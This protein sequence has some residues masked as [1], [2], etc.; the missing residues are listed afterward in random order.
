VPQAAKRVWYKQVTLNDS[1]WTP[2]YPAFDC[3]HIAVRNLSESRV[4]GWLNKTV[5]LRSDTDDPTTEIELD[6]GMQEGIV[7][8]PAAQYK[9]RLGVAGSVDQHHRFLAHEIVFFA[10]SSSGDCNIV[11]VTV[12]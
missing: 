1:E 4:F 10:Q 7:A 12:K 6:A 8:P 11:V 5:F 3:H 9:D 2:I